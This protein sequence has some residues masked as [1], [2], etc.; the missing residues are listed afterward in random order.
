[1]VFHKSNCDLVCIFRQGF[2]V[3]VFEWTKL[4]PEDI[5]NEI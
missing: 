2:F 1:M 3:V 4:N 5:E